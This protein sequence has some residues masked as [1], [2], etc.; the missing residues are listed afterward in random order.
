MRLRLLLLSLLLPAVAALAAE[1]PRL[2]A[3]EAAALLK[4]GQA[5]LVDVREPSEWK[6]TGVAAP[7][8]LLAKSDFDGPKAAWAPFLKSVGKDKTLLLYCRSGN[9]SGKI[10]EALAAQG[11]KVVNAGSL[12]DWAAAGLPVRRVE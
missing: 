2:T 4:Q 12:K 11:Y 7:A 5:V 8:E 3:T 1:V 6:D 10:A 9:R